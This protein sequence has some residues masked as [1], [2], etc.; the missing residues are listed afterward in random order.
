MSDDDRIA[1]GIVEDHPVFRQGL[2][3]LV[4]DAPDL[5][6]DFAVRSVP[7]L[8]TGLRAAGRDPDVLLLDLSLGGGG[9]QGADAVRCVCERGLRV[10]VVSASADRATVVGAIAAGANGYV[11]KAA[12]PQEIVR[13]MRTVAAGGSYLS[14]TLAGYLLD[15]ARA[16]KLTEREVDVLRL[17]AAGDTD[18]DIAE[19]LVISVHTVHSHLDRIRT[20]TGMH[21]RV[22]LTRYAIDRGLLPPP[23][24]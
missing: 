14:P 9:P 3:G 22:D 19:E 1:V 8:D 2:A 10:L 24:A 12:E 21:R 23:G 11:S 5:T 16:I 17:V 18:L 4:E 7:E 6:L 20:K 13:A 15:D